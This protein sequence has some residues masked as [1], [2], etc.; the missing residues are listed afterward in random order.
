MPKENTQNVS[1]TGENLP[2]GLLDEISAGNVEKIVR[3]HLADKNIAR[4]K[5]KYKPNVNRS[6]RKKG[7]W[8]AVVT[9]NFDTNKQKKIF[10]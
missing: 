7:D 5:I 6:E 4:Y 10:Q 3:I 9:I 1:L 2:K 8:H